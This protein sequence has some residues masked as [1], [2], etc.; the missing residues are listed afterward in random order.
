ME[1]KRWLCAA[2][3]CLALALWALP[4]AAQPISGATSE[5]KG[6]ADGNSIVESTH[7][8]RRYAY[9]YS[10]YSSDN[11]DRYY[12]YEEPS[13][14]YSYGYPSYHSYYVY[15]RYDYY[16]YPRYDHYRHSHRHYRD[17]RRW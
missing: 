15:P 4:A 10:E 16:V 6:A 1:I 12:P 5:L 13:Y 3:S 17:Y 14:R 2:V 7:W 8:R 11:F 9:D